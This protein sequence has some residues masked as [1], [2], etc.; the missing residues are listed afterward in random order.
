MAEGRVRVNGNVVRDVM[1]VDPATDVIEIDGRPL[2]KEPPRVYYLLNKPRGYITGRADTRGR[3][4][5]LELVNGLAYRVE[6]VGRL[7]YDTEGALLFTNDGQLAHDLTHPSRQVPKTYMAVVE[8]IPNRTVMKAIRAGVP[9][10]DGPTAPA[11]VQLIGSERGNSLLEITV[12]EGRNR[13]I[14]RMM[15]QLG[16]SVLE[17]RRERF[18][19]I[20]I[21]GLAKGELRELTEEEVRGLRALA[22]RRPGKANKPATP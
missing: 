11:H 14:R 9:L 8:G 2:P 19:S 12:I 17:L 18:A 21:E 1:I 5:V 22:E 10:D 16:H 7:D 13:L 20:T 3:K 15:K 6:P 4:S